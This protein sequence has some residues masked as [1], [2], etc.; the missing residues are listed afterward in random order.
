MT[1]SV[2]VSDP[3]RVGLDPERL[4]AL[5]ERA[6]REVDQGLLPS[7]QLAVARHGRLGLFETLG[8]ADETARYTIFSCTKA[9]VGA[10]AWL[11]MGEG[12][13]HTGMRAAELVPE[14]GSNGKDAITLEHLLTHTGG[15][16]N[17][18]LGAAEWSSKEAR[19]AR[20]ARWRTEYQPGSRFWYHPT[21]AHWVVAHMVEEAAG[22]DY[23]RFIGERIMDPLGL[24]RFQLGVAK[25]IQGDITELTKTGEPPSPDELEAV[26][27]IREIPATE[28]TDEALVGFNDPDTRAVG[29]PG[30]GGVASAADLA[31][32]YQSL[33]HNP[34]G[35]WDHAV[36]ADAT[37]NVRVNL[38]DPVFGTPA[39]RSLGL[40][41][42]GG[43]GKAAER[44]FGRTAGPRSF[45]HGGAAGQIAWADPDSGI[46]F[47]YLT[48]GVDAHTIRVARRG[49]AL[50]SLAGVCVAD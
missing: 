22:P 8:D 28:V 1:S 7:C 40:V 38:P 4:G 21:S 42:A 50:S 13:L 25:D 30:G 3:G 12:K 14:F 9:V 36:L 26:L 10:A 31:L 43:D 34:D 17:A 24:V 46:S 32:F 45:G 44:G 11:L 35:L 41:M 2:T 27:G 47:A 49:V 18:P 20:F 39:S 48:N 16:P 5:V 6:R 29:V 15:F 33:L 37:R 23:R 19:L